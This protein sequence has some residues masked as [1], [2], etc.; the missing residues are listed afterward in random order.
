MS[1]LCLGMASKAPVTVDDAGPIATSFPV[2]EPLMRGLGA[3]LER[4]GP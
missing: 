1:F 3:R 4:E 2:F